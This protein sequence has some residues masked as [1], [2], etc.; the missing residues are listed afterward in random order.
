MNRISPQSHRVHGESLF[1][2]EAEVRRD[3]KKISA[4]VFFASLLPS[5]SAASAACSPLC[6][7]LKRS[8]ANTS[9][10]LI[11]K[12]GT[13]LS[14]F[15]CAQNSP[16]KRDKCASTEC[17]EGEARKASCLDL[18]LQPPACVL[19]AALFFVTSEPLW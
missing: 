4:L 9:S 13:V 12:L 10:M 14:D 17:K 8:T 15:T 19:S 5:M 16:A 2:Q 3:A 1:A 7:P 6:G 11:I 18:R